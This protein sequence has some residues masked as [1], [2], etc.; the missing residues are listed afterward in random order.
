LALIEFL[1]KNWI[2]VIIAL[3]LFS[4]FRKKASPKG[5]QT[6]RS[7]KS[8]MPTFGGNPGIPGSLAGKLIK[9]P[10]TEKQQA[11]GSGFNPP[12]KSSKAS[13]MD[14]GRTLMDSVA[15]SSVSMGSPQT[16]SLYQDAYAEPVTIGTLQTSKQQVAQGIIWAEILGPPRA[17]KP[18]R[19][20]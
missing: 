19:R 18:F 17:K 9:K 20:S 13:L 3:A 8:G 11:S 6:Q 10:E 7:G 16:D 15:S 12:P 4:Q 14:N 2:F 5:D 1:L